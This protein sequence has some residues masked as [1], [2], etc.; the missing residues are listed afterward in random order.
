[1]LN[2]FELSRVW[3]NVESWLVYTRILEG[4]AGYRTMFLFAV[5]CE[6]G[7]LERNAYWFHV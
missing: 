5:F 2:I 7:A 6:I 3:E 1:M 4:L